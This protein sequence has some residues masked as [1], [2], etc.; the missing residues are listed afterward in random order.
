M[1]RRPNRAPEPKSTGQMSTADK[2]AAMTDEE[3]ADELSMWAR[4]SARADERVRASRRKKR[5]WQ[6]K[7][8]APPPPQ[9]TGYQSP[10]F[11]AYLA[12]KSR[13]Y[14]HQEVVKRRSRGKPSSS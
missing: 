1:T 14:V 9:K 10:S 12:R 8:E 5:W 13:G 4:I 11:Q 3:L 2:L 7:P 6:R